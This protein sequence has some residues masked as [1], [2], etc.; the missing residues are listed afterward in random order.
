MIWSGDIENEFLIKL[1]VALSSEDRSLTI[2][3]TGGCPNIATAAVDVLERIPT[4]IIATGACMS[5]AVPILSAGRARK[6]TPRTMFMMHPPTID[7][8]DAS[9]VHLSREK[10]ATMKLFWDSC[11]TLGKHTIQKAEWWFDKSISQ[12]PWYFGV[13]E[14]L[15]LGLIDEVI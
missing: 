14:A 13:D 10:D 3:S 9:V 1:L 5:A 11:V 6:A 8:H 2:C 12:D 15:N 4:E 7:I